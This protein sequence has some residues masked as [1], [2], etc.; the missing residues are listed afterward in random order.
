MTWTEILLELDSMWSS[1]L[2]SSNPD[3][4]RFK[5]RGGKIIQYHGWADAVIATRNSVNYYESVVRKMGG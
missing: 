4:R 2:N 3:L 5:A 1:T